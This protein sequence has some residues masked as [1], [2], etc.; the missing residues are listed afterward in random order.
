MGKPE[1]EMGSHGEHQK[2]KKTLRGTTGKPDNAMGSHGE[3]WGTS[4][5]S[6][7]YN[8]E[9]RGNQAMQ[10][11]AMGNHGDASILIDKV[12]DL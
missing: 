4:K 6:K 1:N 12:H 7:K 8:G 10:W 5:K 2:S 11:G 3:P 9:P